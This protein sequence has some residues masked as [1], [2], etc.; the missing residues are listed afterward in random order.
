[1]RIEDKTGIRVIAGLREYSN[2]F[3]VR[4][5]HV[6]SDCGGKRMADADGDPKS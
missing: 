5:R 4:L 3:T 2:C 6:N 1:M